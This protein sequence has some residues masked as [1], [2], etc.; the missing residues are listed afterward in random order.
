MNLRASI[1]GL[2]KK[3]KSGFT[4]IEMLVV[5]AITGITGLI[6]ANTI[7]SFLRGTGKANSIE[8]LRQIGNY[9]I[10]Q[11]SKNIEYAKTFD[12]VSSDGSNYLLTCP[13]TKTSYN[14]LKISLFDNS[15][16]IYNCIGSTFT[17]NTNAVFDTSVVN[18]QN[19]SISCS[20]ASS[21]TSVPIINISFELRP[22]TSTSLVESSAPIRFETSVVMRNYKR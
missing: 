11:I 5:I 14:F 10:N 19:C 18:V 20:Q 1:F 15:S 3:E 22:T 17:N 16:I 7:A 8:N 21:P 12:G 2:R 6:I 13:V 4:L 9:T